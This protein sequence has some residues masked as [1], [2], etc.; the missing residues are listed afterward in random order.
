MK[1]TLTINLN[2]IVFHI[3]DDA[4]ELLH[5][6]LS[7]VEKHLSEDEKREVMA[8]IEA[9]VAELFS[10][11]LQKNKTVV[12]IEDVQDIINI[13]GSPN[14]YSSEEEQSETNN[15]YQ[16]SEKRKS[17]HYYRDPDNAILGGVCAGVA[18]YF[19]WDV[20]WVRIFTI[21]LTFLTGFNLVWVYLLVW[22]IAP[23]ATTAAHRLEMQGEDVTVENIKEEVKNVKK[24]VESEKFKQNVSTFGDKF[25]DFM[26]GFFKVIF[27]IFGGILGFAGVIVL[28]ALIIGLL[29]LIFEPA[30][31]NGFYPEITGEWSVLTP[32]KIVLL[33]ISLLLIV[34]CPVFMLIYW[35]VR[36]ISG[37]RDFSKTT[38][39]VILILWL[40]GLFMFYSVGAKTVIT[41]R[42]HNNGFTFDFDD[43]NSPRIDQTRTVDYFNQIDVSGNVKVVFT[44]DSTQHLIINAPEKLLDRIVTTVRDGKLRIYTENTFNNHEIRAYINQDSIFK[45]NISGASK[46]ITE[47][48]LRTSALKL[49]LTGA[50]KADMNMIVKEMSDFYIS[51]ASSA[52]V[53]GKTKTARYD[54]SGASKIDAFD[55]KA[56]EVNVRSSGASKAKVFALISVDAN[57][58]GASEIIC[59]G[60]PASVSKSDHFSSSV[61][62]R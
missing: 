23:K 34:G 30:L 55:F 32:E 53:Y 52:K 50:S 58:S 5:G 6:Y 40:A 14:Q 48:T 45:I 41:W 47:D 62:V 16:K 19:S 60:S 10:E 9:R 59:E 42:N 15:S 1:K 43:Y 38:S 2:N 26:R 12:N 31:I 17:K 21:L 54:I 11:K 3:D 39:L 33:I 61:I 51:G 20:T 36:L 35:I 29:V 28:G 37:K 44:Q 18:A 46:F 8:D 13:L 24:F 4:Y 56:D 22:I 27:S 7:D 49:E 25:V 57:A